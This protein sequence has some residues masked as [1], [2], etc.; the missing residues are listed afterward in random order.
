[1]DSQII[2]N[3]ETLLSD[4][5]LVRGMWRQRFLKATAFVA[6][7]VTALSGYSSSNDGQT[8]NSATD[9]EQRH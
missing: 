5:L 9:P 7:R 6:P 8:L 1:M 2:G 4:S 3:N